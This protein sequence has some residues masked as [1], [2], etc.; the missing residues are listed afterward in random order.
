MMRV[1]S[2]SI[3]LCSGAAIACVFT[4]CAAPKD[5][6]VTQ[7]IAMNDSNPV[8]YPV[9]LWDQHVEGETVLLVHV[10]ER[11]QVDS[12]RI[13]HSSGR[14]AFD[15]AASAGA[16]RMRF[17]PGKRGDKYSAMWTRM[18]VRFAMDSTAIIGTPI[19][20]DSGK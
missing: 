4:A 7:P 1:I 19:A 15:S 18:P 6:T 3:R 17:I 8:K 14:D 10:N 12:T 9:A 13:E 11:G 16:R 5:V 20:P 2:R